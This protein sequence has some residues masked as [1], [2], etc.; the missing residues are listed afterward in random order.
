MHIAILTNIQQNT[1]HVI[2]LLFVLISLGT[3]NKKRI[4]PYRI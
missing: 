3:K 1:V 4:I 2:N